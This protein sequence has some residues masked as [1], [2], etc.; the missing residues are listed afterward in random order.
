MNS[1]IESMLRDGALDFS[2]G[3]NAALSP[4]LIQPNQVG[5]AINC[6]FRGGVLK[7]RPGFVYRGL[8]FPS[9]DSGSCQSGFEGGRFQRAQ[10]FDGAGTPVLLSAHGGRIFRIDPSNYHVTEITPSKGGQPDTNSTRSELAWSVQAE[11]YCIFQ[12]NRGLPIIYNGS[13]AR[14]ANP[15]KLEVP[16]GNVMAYAN[17]RLVVSLPDRRTF[18]VGDL[19]FGPSGSPDLQYPGFDA[20]FHGEQ[21]TST[22]AGILPREYSARQPRPARSPRCRR[23]PSPTLP[24]AKGL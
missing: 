22:K 16:T 10:F 6:S 8:S 2:G 15:S 12:D 14:R 11:N 19:V 3:Q 9:Y 7:Q 18:R 1:P 17:G 23:W 4:S 20:A 13:T 21:R 5:Q 24:W